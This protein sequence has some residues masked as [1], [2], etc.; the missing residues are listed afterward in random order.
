MASA[1]PAEPAEGGP[2][3]ADFAVWR[4]IVDSLRAR[5]P[6]QASV[7]NHAVLLHI[8]PERVVLGFEANHFLSAQA[9]DASARDLLLRAVRDHFKRP[10]E[11]VFESISARNGSGT[12]AQAESVERRARIEAAKKSVVEHPLVVAA[13]EMLGAE[14]RDVRLSQDFAEG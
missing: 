9:T 14:I 10:T 2:S 11:I 7:Y 1:R 3:A 13:I 4:G 6:R 5:Y 8:S 12:I